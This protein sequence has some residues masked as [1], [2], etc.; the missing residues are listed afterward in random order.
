[1]RTDPDESVLTVRAVLVSALFTKTWALGIPAPVASATVTC[2]SPVI[3]PK[4]ESAQRDANRTAVA[5]RFGTLRIIFLCT[6]DTC[7]L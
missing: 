2:R 3:C 7:I 6:E 5:I 4:R 1:M